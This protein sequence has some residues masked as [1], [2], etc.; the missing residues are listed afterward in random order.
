MDNR[1]KAH[2]GL[3]ATNIFFALNITLVKQ[4]TNNGF[5]KPFGL[6]LI[7][8]GVSAILLWIMFLF[9]PARPGIHKKDIPRFLLCAFTGIALNQ[10]LFISGVSLTFSI[11]S[12]LLLLVTP[13]VLTII[14]SI[15]YKERLTR[16]KL[17]GLFCGIAGA[18]ILIAFRE[19]SGTGNNVLLGDLLI[20]GNATVYALYFIFVSPLMKKYNAIH[21]IR[22][23]FTFGLVM[24]FP[25][26]W[27]DF[28]K[29]DP[30]GFSAAQYI[31][32]TTIVI[33]GTFLAYLF[34]IYG[35]K[36][37]GP[38]ISGAYIYTQPFFAAIIAMIV[39]KEDLNMYKL[40]A[41][42]L[43]F[44]GV[45]LANKKNIPVTNKINK[46]A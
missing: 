35:I 17:A 19:N 46:N 15:F 39:L 29:I 25:F 44:T 26:C 4:L 7:R 9:K 37:L 31:S 8:I 1:T 21:V 12:A 33:G 16:L 42:V 38:V 32:V 23:V 5:I 14:G 3:L 30:A 10:M 45:Y 2:L 41:A 43:I 27:N 6:N 18:T 24:V 36:I 22:W 28:T 13:I 40:I 11:H 20:A 34:N